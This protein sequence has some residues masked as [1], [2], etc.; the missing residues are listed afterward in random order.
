MGLTKIGLGLDAR[1]KKIKK[2]TVNRRKRK[3]NHSKARKKK[4]ESLA[5]N[6]LVHRARES[7]KNSK[8]K[9]SSPNETIMAAIRSAKELKRSKSV[10]MP[11][12]LKLPKFGGSA[13]TILPILSSLSAI[14]SITASA[15]GVVKAIRDIENAK[16]QNMSGE[17]KIGRGLSLI[18]RSNETASGSGFYLKPYNHQQQQHP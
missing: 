13:L 16:K 4:K 11:R 5:F 3:S 2:I 8:L 18:Y 7:I 10:K 14:G 9:S 1:K 15:A 17:K 12:V 6:K